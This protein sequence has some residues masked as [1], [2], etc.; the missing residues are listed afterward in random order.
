MMTI[1]ITISDF[2]DCYTI[3]LSQH[4]NISTFIHN[5]TTANNQHQ[6]KLFQ[7]KNYLVDDLG[8]Q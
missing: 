7:N 1:M 3:T 5:K 4:D 8:V 2:N 6:M